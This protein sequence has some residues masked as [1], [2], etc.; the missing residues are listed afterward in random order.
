VTSAT[1]LWTAI[2]ADYDDTGLVTLTNIRDRSATSVDTSYGQTQAQAV[3]NL[4][5]AYAD[6]DYDSTDALHVEVA[7]MGV[8]AILWRRGGSSTSI[9][10]VEWDEV[11]GAGGMIERVKMTG[12][13]ARSSPASNSNVTQASG[14][15]ANGRK[16]R[17]WS[18]SVSLPSGILPSDTIARS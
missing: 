6:I 16:K 5:P 8:I 11:F 2:V 9:A 1:E 17:G 10:R 18:E 3:I 7:E 4:W 12:A 15:T 13:R 14:L